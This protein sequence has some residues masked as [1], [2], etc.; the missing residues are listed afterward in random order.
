MKLV[1]L[2]GLLLPILAKA[3]ER[4][5]MG[6]ETLEERQLRAQENYKAVVKECLIPDFSQKKC[7]FLK[8]QSTLQ[9]NVVDQGLPFWKYILL[10]LGRTVSEG[11]NVLSLAFVDPSDEEYWWEEVL[12]EDYKNIKFLIVRKQENEKL[13][14]CQSVCLATCITSRLLTYNNATFPQ[15]AAETIQDGAGVCREFSWVAAEL[16]DLLQIENTGAGGRS[17]DVDPLKVKRTAQGMHAMNYVWVDGKK[18]LIEP[19]QGPIKNTCLFYDADFKQEQLP[20]ERIPM[21]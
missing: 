21:N 6:P 14:D 12:T 16:L 8:N 9:T 13:S 17:Y 2:I 11:L 3:S 18:Y 10:P 5:L 1:L 4:E 7:V 15:S 20:V 19:Q